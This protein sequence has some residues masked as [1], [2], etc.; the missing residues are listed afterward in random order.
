MRQGRGGWSGT[1][2]DDPTTVRVECL[3]EGQ[4]NGELRR[5]GGTTTSS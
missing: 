3:Q 5:A 2:R 4:S 1:P